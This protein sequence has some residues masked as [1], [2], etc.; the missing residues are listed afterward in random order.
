MKSLIILILFSVTLSTHEVFSQSTFSMQYPIAFPLGNTSDFIG[1]A[2][3]RGILLDYR[4]HINPNVAL[5]IGSGWQTF[6]EKLEYGTYTTESGAQAVSGVQYRYLNSLPILFVGDYY[7][8]PDEK[9]SPFIGLGIGITYNEAQT[10]MGQFYVDTDTWQFSL[11]PQ[12]GIRFGSSGGVWG[13][14]SA[15]YNNNF[16]TSELDAQSYLS[17]N[18]G[19]MYG[20]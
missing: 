8:S 7:F 9:F 19:L 11:A 4:Y 1:E 16:E 17:I 10:Q 13:F 18:V 6:Y 2:S 20:Y 3:F 12:A 5:G 14:L 15:R